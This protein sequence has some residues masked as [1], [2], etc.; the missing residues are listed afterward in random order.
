M[1]IAKQKGGG[2]SRHLA[3]CA[4]VAF[5][6]LAR[7]VALAAVNEV[8]F[9]EPGG[10]WWIGLALENTGELTYQVI[11]D[12][13]AYG[14]GQVVEITMS[15]YPADYRAW[16]LQKIP[17]TIEVGGGPPLERW[18][19]YK[20]SRKSDWTSRTL[21]EQVV[22]PDG[23]SHP[24]VLERDYHT[25]VIRPVSGP[26]H[27]VMFRL[28]G[29]QAGPTEPPT[30]TPT[31]TPTWTPTE[32][33]S[34]TRTATSTKTPTQT[35]T[36]TETHLGA[37]V[38]DMHVVQAVG[39]RH[40][41]TSWKD[42]QPAGFAELPFATQLNMLVAKKDT[43]VRVYIEN[44]DAREEKITVTLKGTR[45]GQ[46][47][48]SIPAV[49]KAAKPGFNID[50]ADP[51]KNYN[52]FDFKLDPSW[53]EGQV[54]MEVEVEPR[55][56]PSSRDRV[57]LDFK[58][59]VL[60]VVYLTEFGTSEEEER[61]ASGAIT[62]MRDLY[63]AAVTY[64]VYHDVPFYPPKG[65][66]DRGE[67]RGKPCIK[68]H[69]CPGG[70]CAGLGPKSRLR[71]LAPLFEQPVSGSQT[72]DML[73][74]WGPGKA[75]FGTTWRTHPWGAEGDKRTRPL[76]MATYVTPTA[77]AAK[78][79]L[80]HESGHLFSLEHPHNAGRIP[81]GCVGCPLPSFWSPFHVDAPPY[82]EDL[83]VAGLATRKR[84]AG[85]NDYW[86]MWSTDGGKAPW[87]PSARRDH[88]VWITQEA[89]RK[90]L[91][92]FRQRA[93][94][95]P[96]ARS[97]TEDW[98]MI[99]GHV[100]ESGEGVL[101]PCY[102]VTSGAP[103]SQEG[104]YC[105]ELKDASAQLLLRHCFDA[106]N[107]LDADEGEGGDIDQTQSFV[108]AVPRLDDLA[109]VE[110]VH[111]DVVLF[112]LDPGPAVPVVNIASP[113]PGVT[114]DGT[115]TLRWTATDADGDQLS[116]I[117][118]YSNDDGESWVSLA[119]DLTETEMEVPTDG[120]AGGDAARVRVVVTDGINA[121]SAEVGSLVV[122]EKGPRLFLVAPEPDSVFAYS[123]AVELSA[124][125]YDPEDGGLIASRFQ[126]SSDVD[127]FL[128]NGGKLILDNLS[129]GEHQITVSALD[130][131]EN[132][133]TASVPISIVFICAGDCNRDGQVTVDELIQGVNLALG[134][135]DLPA[136]PEFDTN[137]DATVT[138]DEL[139]RV[140][141]Y[142][143][144]GCP[145]PQPTA[146]SKP[147]P[148][149]A[150][151]QSATSTPTR[152][153][154]RAPTTPVQEATPTSTQTP[155]KT[156]TQTPENTSTPTETPVVG[157][158][159]YCSL[160]SQP[161][162]IP[163][164]KLSGVFDQL[165]IAAEGVITGMDIRLDVDHV[166]V[167]DLIVRLTNEDTGRTVTL[168]DRPRFPDLEFGCEGRDVSV[169][170]DDAAVVS[171]ESRC[172]A[173]VPAV[174]GSCRPTGS[175]SAFYGDELA[176]TWSLRVIDAA[177]DDTG[178]LQGWCL[179]ASTGPPPTPRRSGCP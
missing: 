135:A 7:N 72:A 65:Y 67:S 149:T 115:E 27:S 118:Q 131:D 71:M 28:V 87:A 35:Q 48:T 172:A 8:I 114:W 109:R 16:P 127:G 170:I 94:L 154:T 160:L 5:I 125:G 100:F 93:A 79:V 47:L 63:P 36:P 171:C 30:E 62:L 112:T 57:T 76:V 59:R 34:E 52:S 45:A 70:T 105:L 21:L 123:A 124:T 173:S 120:I 46:P 130:E 128:G 10:K 134:S 37:L 18:M 146:T 161:L 82:I 129:L 121:S 107:P 75:R 15:D 158:L 49:S 64:E 23:A 132:E 168:L 139:V 113:V 80:A 85:R 167:G 83:L 41:V 163:D 136:C 39:F 50:P 148:P 179:E 110:L 157:R 176:G 2:L 3:V 102:P 96:S 69:D 55:Q 51:D 143:L 40:E 151:P 147:K 162:P 133:G 61:I 159:L 103:S 119:V 91:N 178:A 156:R 144:D 9:P 74:Y 6:V 153:P 145:A 141:G 108:E 53:L 12:P 13:D 86:F 11:D 95:S 1:R 169:V 14:T 142:A 58:P 31:E 22:N 73:V 117:V 66:C 26:D 78:A 77:G 33:P 165:L 24:V 56:E 25:L 88:N 137:D 150:T 44:R 4:A 166:W 38:K 104:E 155:E 90:L 17:G 126:W 106:S 138:V 177:T 20:L 122:P 111:N 54:E 92:Q 99:R 98:L 29:G 84:S 140:V 175:L 43:W 97:V 19:F 89:W 81:W 164:G 174:S 32:T 152:T 68:D 42:G 60:K 116:Y 101:A